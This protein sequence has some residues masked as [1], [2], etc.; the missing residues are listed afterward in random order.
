MSSAYEKY[1]DNRLNIDMGKS[2]TNWRRSYCYWSILSA[3][4]FPLLTVV[5]TF[6]VTT[7]ILLLCGAEHIVEGVFHYMHSRIAHI[8]LGMLIIML[9]SIVVPYPTATVT[10]VVL[11][12]HGIVVYRNW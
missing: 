6:T 5:A 2:P 3:I 12:S 7:I 11:L 1:I 8:G 4:T 9:S 10:L